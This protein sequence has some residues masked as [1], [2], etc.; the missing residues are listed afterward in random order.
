M[1]LDADVAKYFKSAEDVNAALRMLIELTKTVR[2]GEAASEQAA[3]ETE[4]QAEE[5]LEQ[6]AEQT[7]DEAADATIEE[8]A[9]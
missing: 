8:K 3:A 2:A 7:A 4:V 6:A 1:R 9:E 5:T